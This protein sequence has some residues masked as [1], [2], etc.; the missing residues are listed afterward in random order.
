MLWNISRTPD[1]TGH[2][3]HNKGLPKGGFYYGGIPQISIFTLESLLGFNPNPPCGIKSCK[4]YFLLLK[5]DHLKRVFLLVE[6]PYEFESSNKPLSESGSWLTFGVWRLLVDGDDTIV[7]MK[8]WQIVLD[9]LFPKFCVGCNR[10][11]EL[12]CEKCWQRVDFVYE[13]GCPVCYEGSIGGLTHAAC[14]SAWGLDG[15]WCLTYYRGPIRQLIRQLKYHQATVMKVVVGEL[16]AS[17]L[18][19]ETVYL[20]AAVMLPV[21]LHESSLRKRGFNQA[22]VVAEEMGQKLALP[23]VEGIVKRSRKTASQTTLN[24]AERRSN[25]RGIFEIDLEKPERDEAIRGETFIVIDDVF[26]SGATMTEMAM[27]LK[28]AGAARVFGLALARD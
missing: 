15:L 20:P 10:M 2:L 25:V 1:Q 9:I 7:S 22:M 4:P 19:R 3:H 5:R 13:Q 17:Y 18:E 21:P 27:M 24:K 8:I 26:T 23:V 28:R 12:L 11:G 6:M 14:R 16:V